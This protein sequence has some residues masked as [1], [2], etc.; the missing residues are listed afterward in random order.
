MSAAIQERPS[1]WRLALAFLFAA[2]AAACRFEGFATGA[3]GGVTLWVLG[4]RMA[5]VPS[6]RWPAAALALGAALGFAALLVV[7]H[8]LSGGASPPGTYGFYTFYDGL[9]FLMWPDAPDE[10]DEWGRYLAS[11]EYLGT[12][13]ENDGSV[14]QALL[15]HPGAAALRF[16]A[17]VP[18]LVGC[19]AWIESLTPLGL[20]AALLGMRGLARRR[21][22][23]APWSRGW[24]FL[25]FAGALPLL[26]VPPAS[27]QYLLAVL[28][29]LL[30]AMARGLDLLLWRLSGRAVAG[31]GAASVAA[32]LAVVILWG[33]AEFPSSPVL[34]KAA[35][36]LEDRCRDGC[37]TNFL[38][39]ALRAQAWVDLQAGSPLPE[40][41]ARSEDFIL[42]R[43]LGAY[44]RGLRFLER[45]RAARAAG[46]R[47]P[48]LYLKIDVRSAQ[49]F[50]PIFDL[51]PSYEGRIDLSRAT[52]E[53][54]LWHGSDR[55]A[56]YAL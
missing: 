27:P 45:V 7:R 3:V 12:F 30:L 26:F 24:I 10:V 36:Y 28:C 44:R 15:S 14:L 4:P 21:E 23:G 17:K 53:K 8:L 22:P 34:N 6:P 50:H 20:G 31:L 42:D 48:V 25:A 19:L 47:G 56:I 29:P 55:V 35:A 52:L 40:R 2:L 41:R 33:R 37:L 51:E 46:Y 49:V 39:P 16:L 18:D 5:G 43:Q 32:G 11:M 1:V 54:E 13:S 38:P 9:P